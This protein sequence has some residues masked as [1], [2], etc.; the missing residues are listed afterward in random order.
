MQFEWDDV[1]NKVNIQKHGIDF[2]DA[3]DI[4]DSPLLEWEQPN[5][6]SEYG[7]I[8]FNALGLIRGYE[9]FAVYSERQNGEVIRFISVRQANK[10]ERENYHRY[11]NRLG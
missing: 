11:T 3:C 8:R 2:Q 9:V 10:N 1:K 4:F 7:E 5:A 6:L